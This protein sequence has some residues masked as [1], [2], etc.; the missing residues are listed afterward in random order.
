M[1]LTR[2][3]LYKKC[4]YLRVILNVQVLIFFNFLF[5]STIFVRDRYHYTFHKFYKYAETTLKYV[6][7]IVLIDITYLL[8]GID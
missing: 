6:G 2:Y 3:Y 1:T 4:R 5:E 7:N 8:G